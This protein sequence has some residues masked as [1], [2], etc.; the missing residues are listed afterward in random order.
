MAQRHQHHSRVIGAFVRI[1]EPLEDGKVR[2]LGCS[3]VVGLTKNGKIRRHKTP[4]GEDCAYTVSYAAPVKLDRLPPVSVPP[5]SRPR[6]RTTI[7]QRKAGPDPSSIANDSRLAP[8]N[9]EC[10]DCGRWLPGERVLCGKC[11]RRRNIKKG[12][13]T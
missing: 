8:R 7:R 1:P 2:C 11:Q 5:E 3:A 13:A 12:R 6:A 9:N 4:A 10:V